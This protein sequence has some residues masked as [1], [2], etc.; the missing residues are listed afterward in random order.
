[1]L[2]FLDFLCEASGRYAWEHPD[3][4]PD[5]PSGIS[6]VQTIQL[7]RLDDYSSCPEDRFF[8]T[9][10]WHYVRTSLKFR[11]D[12]EPCRVISLS[13]RAAAHFLASFCVFLS[14]CA[15]F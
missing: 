12:G 6:G 15:F 9:S 2:S 4:D 14:S 10:T 5:C 13:P 1:L 7:I 3:S 8:A 11:L